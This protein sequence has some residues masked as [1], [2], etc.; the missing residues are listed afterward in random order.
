MRKLIIMLIATSFALVTLLA[1]RV[2]PDN[3]VL[4]DLAVSKINRDVQYNMLARREQQQIAVSRS[5]QRVIIATARA[6]AEAKKVAQAAARARALKVAQERAQ[7]ARR[8]ALAHPRIV[9]TPSNPG[10]IAACIRKWESGGNY[11]AQNPSSTASGA[12]QFLDSTWQHVT[13]LSGRAMNYPPSTQDSAFYKLW[14][15]GAGSGQWT[16]AYHCI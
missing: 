4:P 15:G 11:T 8:Y 16:T 13:G 2:T 12:Y 10:G 3:R 14:N 7:V 6:N 5:E 1:P 9:V